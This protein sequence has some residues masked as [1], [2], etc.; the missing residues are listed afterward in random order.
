MGTLAGPQ[1]SNTHGPPTF[2]KIALHNNGC[3]IFGIFPFCLFVLLFPKS[4]NAAEKLVKGYQSAATQLSH[5]NSLP[6]ES[7]S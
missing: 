6:T 7:T 3:S 5:P 4:S 1:T 2:T